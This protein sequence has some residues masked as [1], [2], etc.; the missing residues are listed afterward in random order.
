[1]FGRLF[2]TAEEVPPADQRTKKYQAAMA[3]QAEAIAKESEISGPRV[4]RLKHDKAD[5]DL[6]RPLRFIAVGCQGSGDDNQR[7]VAALMNELCADKAT[8]PDFILIL[9]DNVYDWGADAAN[10]INIR[11]CFDDIY[12]RDDL[13]H[14]AN[15]PFFFIL[16]NHDENRQN[17]VN[18][19]RKREAGIERGMHEVAH[20]YMED[21]KFSMA[22]KERLYH[23]SSVFHLNN[24]PAWNMPHRYY[25]MI[26]GEVEIFCVDSSTYVKDYLNFLADP[27]G[28]TPE[29]NQAAWLAAETVKARAA[30]RKIILAQHHPLYTPGKRAYHNDLG[31]YLGPEDI[32][33]LHD[34]LHM[35]AD[36]NTPY[37]TFLT[38]CLIRQNIVFDVTLAAHD[39]NLYYYNNKNNP[40]TTYPICQVTAGGGGGELQ[41]RAKF[42]EQED[43]GCFH[44]K[45]GVSIV[46]HTPGAEYFE[47]V[48]HTADHQHHLEFDSRSNDAIIHFQKNNTE[49]QDIEKFHAVVQAALN[50]Y[51]SF[52]GDKQDD[53]SG[54]FLSKR[55]N[56]THGNDGVD[57]A[58]NIWAYIKQPHPK[59]FTDIVQDVYQMIE[60]LNPLKDPAEHSL[61]TILNNKMMDA[62]GKSIAEF[63][64]MND[65]ETILA[66]FDIEMSEVPNEN[67][68]NF[69]LV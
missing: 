69:H 21:S 61:I 68:S 55:Y 62:Y 33:L 9:G 42:T 10:D 49:K 4:Y 13:P 56:L 36:D 8:R 11:K 53:R 64:D 60:W 30:G 16:G 41:E 35:P 54:K 25:A 7:K 18:A 19:M 32:Q 44:S 6:T 67:R 3:Q 46:S 20:S 66:D 47:F 14:L 63:A 15:M 45:H 23:R 31:I 38:E 28:Q 17:K 50:E 12:L 43:M 2:S 24:M 48:L 39:H 57:R 5:D 40:N 59:P 58:H 65:V 22:A 26:A 1:M 29:N 27:I 37:N 51:F 52:L 34:T